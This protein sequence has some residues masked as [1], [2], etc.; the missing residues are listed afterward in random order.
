MRIAFTRVQCAGKKHS[1]TL[2]PVGGVVPT[3]ITLE[4]EYISCFFSVGS[5]DTRIHTLHPPSHIFSRN[6]IPHQAVLKRAAQGGVP[7]DPAQVPLSRVDRRM[8]A[9]GRSN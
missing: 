7:Q 6:P 9:E 2:L 8:E 4:N 5:T 1:S 3:K